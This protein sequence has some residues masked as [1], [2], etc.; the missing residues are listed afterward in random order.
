MPRGCFR[1]CAQMNDSAAPASRSP[2][3]SQTRGNTALSTRSYKL[4]AGFMDFWA[5]S[6]KAGCGDTEDQH[7]QPTVD[8]FFGSEQRCISDG[9]RDRS[10]REQFCPKDQRRVDADRHVERASVSKGQRESD[11]Q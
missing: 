6:R 11:A 2:Q 7:A 1:Q 8:E 5:P 10:E 4:G 3:I 9:I